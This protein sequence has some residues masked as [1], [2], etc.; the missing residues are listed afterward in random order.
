[1][2]IL[3]IVKTAIEKLMAI[4]DPGQLVLGLLSL[5]ILLDQFK[6]FFIFIL[7]GIFVDNKMKKKLNQKGFS[8]EIFNIGLLDIVI[9]AKTGP[10]SKMIDRVQYFGGLLKITKIHKKTFYPFLRRPYNE[11]MVQFSC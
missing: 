3:N 10:G 2:K 6:Y 8:N 4:L 5:R 9:T 11:H 1:M 7:F